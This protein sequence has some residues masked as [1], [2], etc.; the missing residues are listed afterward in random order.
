MARTL[1]PR[2]PQLD[3]VGCVSDG[4]T[5]AGFVFRRCLCWSLGDCS[6]VFALSPIPDFRLDLCV[7]I[8]SVETELLV[9]GIRGDFSV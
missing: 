9:R 3:G 6:M 4:M 7:E 8:R 1:T 2:S 5:T